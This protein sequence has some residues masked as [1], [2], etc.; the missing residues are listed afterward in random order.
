[1]T[2]FPLSSDEIEGLLPNY[3]L[4]MNLLL[5]KIS[6]HHILKT[7]PPKDKLFMQHC[8]IEETFKFQ[9]MTIFDQN[10]QVAGWITHFYFIDCKM[11]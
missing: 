8:S 2:P 5:W 3:Q 7:R 6:N 1:M 10:R 4:V 11:D 9:I